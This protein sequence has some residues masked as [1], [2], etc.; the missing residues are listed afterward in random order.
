MTHLWW[1]IESWTGLLTIKKIECE[2]YCNFFVTNFTSK[3]L[4]KI[5]VSILYHENYY[6]EFFE[7]F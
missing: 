5:H 3:N 1:E 2:N 7:I 6:H 4:Q